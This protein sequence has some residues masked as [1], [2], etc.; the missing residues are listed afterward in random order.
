MQRWS[1]YRPTKE[2]L[3][4]IVVV[5]V[6]ATLIIGF[7]F[8]GWVTGGTAQKMADEAAATS[9]NQLAAAVCAREFMR[10]ADARTRLAKLQALDWWER[11]DQVVA[12]GWATMPGEKE[13]DSA[14]AELCA[15]RL[16]DPGKV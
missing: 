13:A 9:R 3:F 4:W 12:G 6:A 11:D 5:C 16:A 15:T 2:H 7:G 8:S 1:E 14:V 10:A